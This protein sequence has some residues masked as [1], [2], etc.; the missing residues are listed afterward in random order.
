[1]EYLADT[2]AIVR[3]FSKTGKIGKRALKI[4]RDT[5]AGEHVIYVSIISIVEIM[6]LAERNRIPVKLEETLS[7]IA[8]SDNYHIVDLDVD[9]IQSAK[10]IHGLELHDRLIVA[11]A[12][13]LNLPILTND[14]VIVK[15]NMIEA[16]WDL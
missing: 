12:R 5:D 13:Q 9:T 16:I 3:Y 2:V 6:Y 11:S 4:L 14:T 10:T 8:I 1:M 7:K 15:S